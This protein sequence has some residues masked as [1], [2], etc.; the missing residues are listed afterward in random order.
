M[1]KKLTM[2]MLLLT[3]IIISGIPVSAKTRIKLKKKTATITVGKTVQLK[4]I[5]TGKYKKVTWSS[6]N[7][8]IATVN[9]SGKVTGKK[10]GTVTITAKVNGKTAKCKITVITLKEYVYKTYLKGYK[11][12]G[13]HSYNGK[14]AL[15]KVTSNYFI[16]GNKKYKYT[17]VWHSN[18]YY[19]IHIEYQGAK[20][21]RRL[22]PQEPTTLWAS[23]SDNPWDISGSAS[24]DRK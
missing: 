20:G 4:V 11:W 8:K 5:A 3:L 13:R 19:K 1:K 22:Y 6:S 12:V 23:S 21:H 17:V 15:W 14:S 2:W 18:G 16:N 10:A 7:K 9:S 24:L